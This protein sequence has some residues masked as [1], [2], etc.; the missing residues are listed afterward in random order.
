MRGFQVNFEINGG[1][2]FNELHRRLGLIFI[3]RV[4]RTKNIG[5]VSTKTA[6]GYIVT[7]AS[8][9]KLTFNLRNFSKITIILMKLY[10]YFY[11]NL[12]NSLQ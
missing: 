1:R 8:V 11:E 9:D 2:C 5:F 6:V 7:I 4:V 12:F 10:S 3:V